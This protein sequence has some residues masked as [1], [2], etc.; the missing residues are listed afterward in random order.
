M[1]MV[2]PLMA[3]LALSAGTV[4]A[5]PP[6]NRTEPA[7]PFRVMDNVFQVG[8]VGISAWLITASPS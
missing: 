5:Q 8:S 1:R 6:A 2:R 4:A 7:A 3:A